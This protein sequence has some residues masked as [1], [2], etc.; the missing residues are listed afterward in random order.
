MH[1]HVLQKTSSHHMIMIKS[2]EIVNN[3][4]NLKLKKDTI[5]MLFKKFPIIFSK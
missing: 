1:V 5:E 3:G 4:I 2:R